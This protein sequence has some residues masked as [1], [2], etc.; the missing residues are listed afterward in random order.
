MTYMEQIKYT[1]RITNNI[2]FHIEIRELI[3]V[4]A[5]EREGI[6][7]M[8]ITVSRDDLSAGLRRVLPVVSSRTTLPVLNNV[9]LETDGEALTLTTTDL[10]VCIRTSVPAV[11]EQEGATTLPAKK[12]AQIVGALPAGN[13]ILE[14]DANL[15]TAVSCGKSFF[16]IVGLDPKEFPRD[17][18]FIEEWTFSS[19]ADVLKKSLSKVSYARSNDEARH[20]LNGI[21]LSVRAGTLT[22]AAT[23]GRRLAL[24]DT[25]VEDQDLPDGDVILPSKVVGELEKVLQGDRSV[26]VKL[27]ESRAVFDCG[28][29]VITSKLVEGTYPN[30]RQVVP[31]NFTHSVAI[32]RVL[33]SEVLTRVAMVVSESS[34]SV[35]IK[36]EPAV[37]TVSATSN[38][39]GEAEEPLDVSYEGKVFEIAFNPDFFIDPLRQLECD[40]LFMAFNDEYSPVSLSGDEGFLYVVMPMRG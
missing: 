11:V 14:T 5:R 26:T 31:E 28:D 39:F 18:D 25:V 29:T 12:F 17:T 4:L 9:L 33:F 35:R 19:A 15:Q 27:A 3:I 1:G 7:P 21:L 32:P 23:D 34:S 16:R 30:Y 2:V 37:M 38:E 8:R 10:E 40:Q 13:V 24:I 20:V 36:L 6:P 22:I